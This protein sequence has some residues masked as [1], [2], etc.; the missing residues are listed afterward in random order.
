MHVKL[1][2]VNTVDWVENKTPNYKVYTKAWSE[3]GNSEHI[4]A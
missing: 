3:V 4:P 1:A 2:N